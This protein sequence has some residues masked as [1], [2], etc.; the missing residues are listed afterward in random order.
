MTPEQTVSA[1]EMEAVPASGPPPRT[2]PMTMVS[3]LAF[4]LIA[5]FLLLPVVV[6]VPLSFGAQRYLSFPNGNWSLRHYATLTNPAWI[7]SISQSVGLALCVAIAST[8][9]AF[10]FVTGVWIRPRF[11]TPLVAIVLIPMIV[12][13][14][15]SAMSMYYLGAR[16]ATLDTLLGVGYGHFLMAMPYSVISMLVAYSRVDRKIYQASLSL[17]ASVGRTMVSVL[18]PN[19]KAG[20]IGSLA[21]AFVT[22][23]EEVVV[24]LFVSGINVVTVPKRIWDGLRYDLDPAVAAISTVM[25]VITTIVMIV[26]IFVSRK[27]N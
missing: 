5:V 27:R 26:R 13:Q 14:V 24:T 2:N 10:I 16:T 8:V 15:V 21:I 19:V 1:R 23:W 11:R 3:W 12:P 20:I 6:I 22:S 9:L 4:A 7:A 17:G 25:I 18:I